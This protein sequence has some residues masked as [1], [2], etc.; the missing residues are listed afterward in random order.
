MKPIEKLQD[1]FV[2]EYAASFRKAGN[3][4][5]VGVGFDS[6]TGQDTLEVR[7][8]NDNLKETLP[9]NYY[10]TKVRIEVIGVVRAL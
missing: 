9:T 10:G 7:L 8:T 5:A 1:Q 6:K 2:K 3:N 4:L